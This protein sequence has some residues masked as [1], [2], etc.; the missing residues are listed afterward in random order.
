MTTPDSPETQNTNDVLDMSP[1]LENFFYRLASV[2]M[3]FERMARAG[4]LPENEKAT[5][6]ALHL[7]HYLASVGAISDKVVNS[8]NKRNVKLKQTHDSEI[9]EPHEYRAIL[10]GRQKRTEQT[11]VN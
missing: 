2:S 9:I 8:L 6:T 1:F 4:L 10:K 7:L 5:H 3:D 11:L